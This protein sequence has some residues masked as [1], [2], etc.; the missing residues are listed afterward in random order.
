MQKTLLPKLL[1]FCGAIIGLLG[2]QTAWTFIADT[3]ITPHASPEVQSVLAYFSDIYGQKIIS[4]QQENWR[5]TEKPSFEQDYLRD[6]TGK[7]PGLVAMDLTGYSSRS[8]WKDPQHTLVRHAQGCFE[9]QHALVSFCWHWRPPLGNPSFSAKDATFDI[10]RAVTPGTPEYDAVL[11]DMDLIA[12]EL[13]VLRDAHVPVLWRPLHEANGRW[14]WWGMHGPEPFKQLWRMMFEQLAVKHQLTNLIWVYSPGAETDLAAWYPG[15]AYVD[16]IGQDLYPMDGN[17]GVARDIFDELDVLGGGRKL[18]ALAENGPVPDPVALVKE[19][20]GWLFFTTWSGNIL[21][22][23]NTPAQLHDLFNSDY[24]LN[25][26]DLPDLRHYPFP[27]TGKPVKLDFHRAPTDV[28]VNG[29]RYIPLTVTV[30]DKHGRTIREGN[31]N[32]TIRLKSADG[33]KLSGTLTEPAVNGVATFADLKINAPGS[34][35]RLVAN[36]T[37]LKRAVSPKF[38]VGPGTG[39][40]YDWWTSFNS[41]TNVPSGEKFLADAVILPVANASEFAARIHGYILAPETGGY[42]FWLDN[43]NVSELW[44]SPDDDSAHAVKIAE[45]TG[46]TPYC[47]WPHTHEAGSA[48]VK[49]AAGQRYYFEVRQWQPGGSTQFALRWQLPDGREERPV[50]AYRIIADR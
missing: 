44:L 11:K 45:V 31:Y 3:P 49:L 26:G 16:I 28:A 15:D 25:Q 46:A 22:D 14:F 34:D 10:T 27:A 47:K 33:G 8:T 17:H 12:A 29:I 2:T 24:V 42:C 9:N 37:R 1:G 38:S 30:E 41:F 19:K 4:G 23:A 35:Y 7:L 50:P 18:I 21:T 5:F 20:A 36:A 40:I 6:K 32:I 39:P 48:P 13:T 43:E